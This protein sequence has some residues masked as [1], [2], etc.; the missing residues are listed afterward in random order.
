MSA[1]AQRDSH[2]IVDWLLQQG[3]STVNQV[4]EELLS[5]PA[6]AEQL[7]RVLQGA[8]KT[9]GK[10]DKNVE[11]LLHLLNLPSRADHDKLRLKIDHLQGS[12]VNL[13]MKLDR[14]LAAQEAAKEAAKAAPRKKG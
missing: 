10:V 3:G 5:R 11:M 14:L 1:K 13:N 9:K 6:V 2:N 7:G 8:A 4:L 12:L